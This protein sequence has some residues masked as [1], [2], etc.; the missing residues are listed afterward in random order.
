MDHIGVTE[1]QSA[2][3][4]HIDKGVHEAKEIRSENQGAA[5]SCGHD[6]WVMQRIADSYTAIKGHGGEKTTFSTSQEDKEIHLSEAVHVRNV[7]GGCQ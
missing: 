2:H 1:I 6:H 3:A 4:K 7:F 5:A